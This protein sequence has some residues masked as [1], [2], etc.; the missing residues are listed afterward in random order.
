MLLHVPHVTICD[1]DTCGCATVSAHTHFAHAHKQ[2]P[3]KSPPPLPPPPPSAISST[4]GQ[5][6]T[7]AASVVC[8]P[9]VCHLCHMKLHCRWLTKHS[10]WQQCDGGRERGGSAVTRRMLYVGAAAWLGSCSGQMV[11]VRLGGMVGSR[12]A[13]PCAAAAAA[14]A[15]GTLFLVASCGPRESVSLS[16]LS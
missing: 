11:R 9:Y 6:N 16:S 14:V 2:L 12:R 10:L 1:S 8:P 3:V 7:Y 15:E 5:H 13:P 4:V